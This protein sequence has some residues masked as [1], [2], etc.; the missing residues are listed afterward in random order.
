MIYSEQNPFGFLPGFC[1]TIEI[2][3]WPLSLTAKMPTS[4]R[5]RALRK[6]KMHI[7]EEKGY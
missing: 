7:A 3:G 4:A 2:P 1:H 5:N 6:E